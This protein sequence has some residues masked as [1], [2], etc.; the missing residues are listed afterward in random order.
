MNTRWL[1]SWVF[2][3]CFGGEKVVITSVSFG[4]T[5]SEPFTTEVYSPE[6][7]SS[8]PKPQI[9][10]LVRV[11]TRSVYTNNT[12]TLRSPVFP[13]QCITQSHISTVSP[14]FTLSLRTEET[15]EGVWI[16]RSWPVKT[17]W[18]NLVRRLQGNG[19]RSVDILPPPVYRIEWS[20]LV[21]FL[22]H[23]ITYTLRNLSSLNSRG[24]LYQH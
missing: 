11:S 18:D 2:L 5:G 10:T 15:Q 19:V 3:I 9:T 4:S 24:Y 1:G 13:F 7:L 21:K 20:V 22:V 14:V 23:P 8:V 16:L 12:F 17:V 6:P